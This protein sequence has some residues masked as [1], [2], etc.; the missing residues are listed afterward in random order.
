MPSTVIRRFHYEP[1]VNRLVIEFQSGRRYAYS[2]VPAQTYAAFRAAHS[3]GAFFNA[4][5][6]DRYTYE[7]LDDERSGST[8]A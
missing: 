1:D 7:C 8:A 4:W 3:R 5:I 6:R 2:D